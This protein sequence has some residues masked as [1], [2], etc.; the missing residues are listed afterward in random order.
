MLELIFARVCGAGSSAHP[1]L[2]GG[3][4]GIGAAPARFRHCPAIPQV[5]R[6]WRD[7]YTQVFWRI[8]F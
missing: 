6:R 8:G 1:L 5:C 7:V 3:G 4:G 2:T